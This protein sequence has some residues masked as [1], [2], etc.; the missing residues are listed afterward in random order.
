MQLH[1]KE[2]WETEVR[3]ITMLQGRMDK[4]FCKE[5]QRK[6]C[7]K[8]VMLITKH[9]HKYNLIR[10][11]WSSKEVLNYIMYKITLHY[12]FCEKLKL[13]MKD[14][15]KLVVQSIYGSVCMYMA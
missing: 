4:G 6:N 2:N 10:A 9:G 7:L 3:I 1:V 11:S 8:F 14:N 15:P 5:C 12:T 13:R